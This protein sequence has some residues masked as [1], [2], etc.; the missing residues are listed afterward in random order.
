[1]ATVTGL[2]AEKML[3]LAD[4]QV[5]GGGILGDDLILT[6]RG[7]SDIN[8]GDVRGPQG[9][10]SGATI[11]TQL[12]R[13]ASPG[14]GQIIYETDTRRTYVW[15][16][17][18]WD[19]TQSVW[20]CTSSTRPTVPWDGSIIYET[21]TKRFWSWNGTAWVYR[22]GLWHCTF[23][24]RPAGP[25]AGFEIY[26]TDTKRRFLH[27]GTQYHQIAGPAQWVAAT[28]INGWTNT[29]G[30]TQTARY[31]K[32]NGIVHLEGNVRNGSGTAFVLPAGFRPAAT[33]VFQGSRIESGSGLSYQ[34][35]MSIDAAGNV[36]PEEGI[37][38]HHILTSFVAS[39]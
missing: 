23:A 26:E 10:A 1:M 19:P 13:P 3:E 34:L 18:Y 28:L 4:E 20:I 31:C 15:N 9:P 21:D 39:G 12:T 36:W 35:S 37:T 25:F 29:G 16:G 17:T 14:L 11:C 27:D 22:S 8:A 33:I 2:T 38:W 30:A 32:M 5:V 6:T 7:G 24:T